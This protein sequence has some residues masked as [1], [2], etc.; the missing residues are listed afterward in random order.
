M[1]GL[2]SASNGCVRVGEAVA[3]RF[4]DP[5]R[6]TDR[7]GRPIPHNFVL[8][9]ELTERVETVEDGLREVWPLVAD[10]FARVWDLPRAPHPL[11]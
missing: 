2:G 9:D 7:S 3:L 5:E 1:S 6:R 4:H 11:R 8:Y 10:D